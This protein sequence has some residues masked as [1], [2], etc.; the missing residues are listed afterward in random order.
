MKFND[1]LGCQKFD[2]LR[3]L[4]A[5]VGV[6]TVDG[7]KTTLSQCGIGLSQRAKAFARAWPAIQ[8]SVLMGEPVDFLLSEVDLPR[9]GVL[10]PR[11]IRSLSWFKPPI[12]S[13]RTENLEAARCL[14]HIYWSSRVEDSAINAICR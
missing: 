1:T 3:D 11:I 13:I 5:L 6:P 14:Q 7:Q 12:T 8:L 4:V 9:L 2:P 10:D